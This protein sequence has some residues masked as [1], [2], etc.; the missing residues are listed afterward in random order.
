MH[1]DSPTPRNR[2]LA[3]P[4]VHS[5]DSKFDKFG[6]RRS[7]KDIVVWKHK[8]PVWRA[9]VDTETC[10]LFINFLF[11]AF[12][13]FATAVLIVYNNDELSDYRPVTLQTPT[14]TRGL[15]ANIFSLGAIHLAISMAYLFY[16]HLWS[17]MLAAAEMN[18]FVKTRGRLRVTLPLQGTQSTYYLSIKPHISALMIIALTLIHFFTTR[19]L[20]VVFIQTYDIMGHYSHQRI[21]YGI[22]TASAVLALGLGFLMLCALTFGLERRLH[23]GMPVL[24]T[25]SMAI[26]AACHADNV[27][28]SLGQV[29]YGKNARTGKMSFLSYGE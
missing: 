5:P 26:S 7:G 25:C 24:G 21:T 8:W 4:A 12:F 14:S 3:I 6:F 15:L 22:S 10:A 23:S 9:A 1:P 20:S 18:A 11:I 17:R 13:A 29:G 2:V 28:M 19:A 27:V 16:N